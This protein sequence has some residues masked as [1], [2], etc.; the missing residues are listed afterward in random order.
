MQRIG[1]VWRGSDG[2]GEGWLI[3]EPWVR[4]AKC[5]GA[6]A[7]K[8]RCDP[9]LRGLVIEAKCRRRYLNQVY[10]NPPSGKYYCHRQILTINLY[11]VDKPVAAQDCC[12][13]CDSGSAARLTCRVFATERGP[14]RA[15]AVSGEVNPDMLSCLVA[16]REATFLRVFGPD[17]LF[18]AEALISD[19]D[20]ERI[21]RCASVPSIHQ[22]RRYL[23]KWPDV[24]SHL[25]SMWN[26]LEEGGFT[27][28]NDSPVVPPPAPPALPTHNQLPAESSSIPAP[29][30]P[31]KSRACPNIASDDSLRMLNT[32]ESN[33]RT[34]PT[35]PEVGACTAAT[36]R[37]RLDLGLLPIHFVSATLEHPSAIRVS[38]CAHF[39]FIPRQSTPPIIISV[40]ERPRRPQP[41][42]R[43]PAATIYQNICMLRTEF[44]RPMP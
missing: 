32:R 8:H 3:F 14:P 17:S 7:V 11:R 35:T 31:S 1:R 33:K 4:N 39:R 29:R 25:E 9:I 20:I 23:I 19:H 18:G 41:P 28:S 38:N 5:G 40:P 37:A 16:W 13:I 24:D 42:S 12:D 15:A 34:Q 26:A 27:L 43:Y 44:R 2:A 30:L 10:G 22:L 36:K 6:G 21:S